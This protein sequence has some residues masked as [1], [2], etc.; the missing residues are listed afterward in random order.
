MHGRCCRPAATSVH[1][2]TLATHRQDW[3]GSNLSRREGGGCGFTL[4]RSHSCCAVQLVHKKIS[5]GHIWTTLYILN[6][7]VCWNSSTGKSYV[8]HVYSMKA[9]R[10]SKIYFHLFLTS[11]LH[12][13]EWSILRP[14]RFPPLPRGKEPRHP[15]SKMLSAAQSLYGRFGEEQNLL[16]L[17]RF[18]P[19]TAQP[20]T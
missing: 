17:P 18:E 7:T 13:C 11:A 8:A 16:P 10:G 15:F 9:Y 6:C 2:T 20:W 1:Y 4:S 5:P 3:T 19:Q 12:G 14:G